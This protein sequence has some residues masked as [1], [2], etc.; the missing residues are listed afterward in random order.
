MLPLGSVAADDVVAPCE[1]PPG[2]FVHLPGRGSMFVRDTGGP[3]GAPVVILLHGLGA[4]A[5]LNW[6][7]TFDA[8]GHH[9]RVIAPDHRGHGRGIRSRAPFRLADCAGDVLALADALGVER[10]TAVGYS[11]GGP[12]AQLTWRAAPHRVHGLVICASSRDFRGHPRERLL[13]A[14]V[15]VAAAATHLEVLRVAA[16]GAD[17][18]LAPVFGLHRHGRWAV[19]ELRR[20][21]VDAVL[22]A[23]VELGRFSSR[24]WI[25]EVDV[26][27]AVIVTARDHLVPARRQRRLADLIPDAAVFEIVEGHHAAA[28][29]GGPF[30]D[31]LVGACR[32]VS[33]WPAPV[34]SRPSPRRHRSVE[35]PAQV[36][37]VPGHAAAAC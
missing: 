8:L 15:G 17:R 5:D 36:G 20:S 4:N 28:H 13:Y 35:R 23:G 34:D 32:A 29:E 27:T 1:L 7:S 14:G 26:P 16:R 22:Q 9:F 21:D 33:P 11:M 19:E 18:V 3:P 10:F 24:D 30:V 25:G 12:V 31:A 6:H 2:R 37:L